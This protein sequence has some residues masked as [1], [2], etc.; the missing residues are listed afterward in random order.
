[1]AEGADAE[2]RDRPVSKSVYPPDAVPTNGGHILSLTSK[3]NVEFDIGFMT[4]LYRKLCK[5]VIRGHRGA[6]R[7]GIH[8][9]YSDLLCCFREKGCKG[10]SL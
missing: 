9:Q 3:L 2:A 8:V 5:L 6:I 7:V 10:K 1:M 4:E